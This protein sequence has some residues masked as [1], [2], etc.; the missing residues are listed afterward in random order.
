MGISRLP[1]GV[2]CAGLLAMVMAAGCGG[3]AE[4]KH[5]SAAAKSAPAQHQAAPPAGNP[6]HTAVT[7]AAGGA[8]GAMGAEMVLTGTTGCGHCNFHKTEACAVGLE[9]ADGHFYVIDNVGEDTELWNSRFAG[10]KMTVKGSVAA[11]DGLDHVQMA[12]FEW[13]Q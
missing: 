11:K 12:S 8:A 9:T 7:Q 3:G 5:D 13:V 1:I 6:G 10:K 4:T 2:V